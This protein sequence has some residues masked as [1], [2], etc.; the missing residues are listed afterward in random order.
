MYGRHDCKTAAPPSCKLYLAENC[1]FMDNQEVISASPITE[2]ELKQLHK[3]LKKARRELAAANET[4]LRN[5]ETHETRQTLLGKAESE[6]NMLERYMG[7]I[8]TN[9][10]DIILIFD[11]DGKLI[12]CTDA[13]LTASE[14]G[15]SAL[16]RGVDYNTLLS[17]AVSEEMINILRN[18]FEKKVKPDKTIELSEFID[19][20]GTGVR[21]FSVQITAMTDT[22]ETA[23][24][25]MVF[26]Y[27]TTELL[28]AKH[29]AERA[30]AAKSSF[31]ATISHEIRTPM[32]AVLGQLTMMRDT[33]LS[34]R[35]Y[36]LVNGIEK[37]SKNLLGLIND[38][39]DFSKID[40]GKLDIVYDWF[41]IAAVVEHIRSVFTVLIGEKGLRFTIQ[42]N[43][44]LPPCVWGDEK[45]FNQVIVNLLS[46]AMKY[47]P[48][49]RVDFVIRR[50]REDETKDFDQTINTF[51]VFEVRD[52]GIG[53]RP[54]DSDRLFRPFEQLDQVKNKK[55]TG[56]GLGLVITK[57]LCELMGGSISLESVYGEG[58]S[59]VITLPMK[60]GE[61]SDI[62]IE[63]EGVMKFSAPDAEVLIVDDIEINIEIAQF[64]L[65]STFGIK[66]ETALSGEEALKKCASK[67][68]DIIFMDHMMP[69][70]DGIEA[71]RRLRMSESVN[72]S[73]NVIAL[74]AN[75]I[76]GIDEMFYKNGFNGFVS[77]PMDIGELSKTL[78]KLLPAEKIIPEK[79]EEPK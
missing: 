49:G 10:P 30:N 52:T 5:R 19:F 25:C 69:E 41:D 77:K 21:S 76:S 48:E 27:D 9:C 59:F 55:V 35:Q 36:N 8:L 60:E 44:P 38:I 15:G 72:R 37:S 29:A 13:F 14:I 18:L 24:S 58:S 51:W 12:Y 70:M 53:I 2:A 43:D 62:R 16:V 17:G 31:L 74:T 20:S 7:L 32:N 67:Q 3:E 39:L 56:T 45:R 1:F 6:R 63:A 66:A 22:E 26:F 28:A 23:Q 46:N 65:E 40:A 33:E 61:R 79:S 11:A 75:A 42:I 73:T 34:E 4:L 54:E 64:L 47:T 68:Y 57:K 78:Q 50:A 71:V